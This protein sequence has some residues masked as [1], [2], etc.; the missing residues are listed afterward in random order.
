MNKINLYSRA[1]YIV[2]WK[3]RLASAITEMKIRILCVKTRV[4]KLKD[5]FF[6]VKYKIHIEQYIKHMPTFEK[7]VMELYFILCACVFNFFWDSS[8]WLLVAFFLLYSNI[9][10][11]STM[12]CLSILLLDI[13]VAS[14]LGV[15]STMT[16]RG[17]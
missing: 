1:I 11:I 7:I 9:F 16:L 4:F 5:C 14:G 15:S 10:F 17:F 8:V 13:W 12:L 3:N 2:W 6:I